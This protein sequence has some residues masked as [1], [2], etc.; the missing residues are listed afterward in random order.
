MG[1]RWLVE[2]EV[3]PEQARRDRAL[4]IAPHSADREAI[5]RII[6]DELV[7][8]VFSRRRLRI[9]PTVIGRM[10][11]GGLRRGGAW[12]HRDSADYE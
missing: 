11:D 5:N 9:S 1:T 12:L 10:K 2:S 8:G 6:M 7:Y 4:S 3:Y